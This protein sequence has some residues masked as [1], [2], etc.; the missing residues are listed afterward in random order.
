MDIMKKR[1]IVDYAYKIFLSVLVIFILYNL[2]SIFV[3]SRLEGK[4]VSSRVLRA[5]STIEANLARAHPPVEVEEEAAETILADYAN[6]VP[7]NKLIVRNS[8]FADH[9]WKRSINDKEVVAEANDQEF[10]YIERE[11]P[12]PTQ[13][14]LKGVT[15]QLALVKVR[16]K[17]NEVWYEHSFPLKNSERIG[18]EKIIR[19]VKYDFKTNCVI[20]DIISD[21]KRPVT[22][23]KKVVVLSDAGKFVGTKM[24]PGE[25]FMKNTAK[26]IYKDEEGLT[27]ELWVG[28]SQIITEEPKEEP[29]WREDPVGAA[30]FK[31]ENVSTDIKK[32]LTRDENQS[33]IE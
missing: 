5:T 24:V 25:T 19:N 23:R 21:V 12:V 1:K 33:K 10:T 26:M 6:N 2:V 22:L 17:I 16:R 29:N 27:K 4:K 9:T 18:A 8:I 14:A 3:V 20:E 31:Y 30:K 32:K 15:G 28:E 13:I 11:I 7:Y